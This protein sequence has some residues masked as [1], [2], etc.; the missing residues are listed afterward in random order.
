MEYLVE[1]FTADAQPKKTG[2][3]AITRKLSN[4][5]E[6]LKWVELI[7]GVFLVQFLSQMTGTLIQFKYVDFRLLFVVIMGSIYGIKTGL[8]AAVLVSIS[9][10][11]TWVQLG[12]DWALLVYNVG[13]WLPFALYFTAGL[14]TGYY[15]DKSENQILNAEKQTR[16]ISDKYTFLYGVFNDIRKLKDE[17]RERLLG[18]R[19][20]FGKIYTITKEL[21]QLQE[22]SIYLRAIV[23]QL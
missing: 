4:Y 20:S 10:L 13:N 11:Y 19:D 1:K 6:I 18:Y 17:F 2:F 14:I 7:G 8:Y 15:H 23:R 22:H 12:F 21:D 16:L 3:E 9:I 5:P